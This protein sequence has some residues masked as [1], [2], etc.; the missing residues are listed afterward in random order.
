MHIEKEH[1][2]SILRIAV[3]AVL[4]VCAVLMCDETARIILFIAA[5]AAA[6]YAVLFEAVCNIAH[7]RIFDENFLMAAASLGALLLGE[8]PE[9]VAVMLFYQIGELFEDMAVERSRRSISALLELVPQK[10]HVL[11]NGEVVEAAPADVSVGEELLVRPGERVPLDGIVLEGSSELDTSALTGESLTR[12]VGAGDEILSGSVN[13]FGLLRIRAAKAYQDSAVAKIIELVEKASA[14]KAKVE[15][16]ITRF[17]RIYTPS[18]ISAAVFL[19]LIPPLVLGGGWPEWTSR[20]LIFLVVSCPCALVISVPLSFFAGIGAASRRG[21]LVKG[22]TFLEVLSRAKTVVFDKTGTLTCGKSGVAAEPGVL[23]AAAYAEAQSSHPAAAAIRAAFG[24]KIDYSRISSVSERPGLG[25][26]AVVDSQ[27]VLAGSRRLLASSGIAVPEIADGDV[28]IAKSGR[29]LGTITLSDA[30]K[31]DAHETA[32]ALKVLGVSR[33]VMLTGDREAAAERTAK[34]AGIAEFRAGLLP[35]EK[36]SALEELFAGTAGSL[37]YVGD[38]I[39]D[40][41]VLARAD[42]GI[43]M[44]ALGSDA[45]IE[46]ADVVIMDDSLTKI[47]DALTIAK[48]TMRTVKANIVFALGVKA[49]VLVLAVFGAANMW[50]AVFADVGVS[51]LCILNAMRL[52]RVRI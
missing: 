29:F 42:C 24:E 39:N 43:A 1:I 31:P 46:S 47:A 37:V 7:G 9:A 22:S 2:H 41:P 44:G 51:V 48:R 18:V 40:A 36:V 52:L 26:S 20:A 19:A 3:S 50:L 5:Y 13:G 32:A 17:A 33:L 30:V 35:E 4:F 34:A 15:H 49:A 27:P 16:F 45:A 12:P 8:F 14:R 10:A 23:A 38:G 21:I 28:F 11:Q 6:S 25:V